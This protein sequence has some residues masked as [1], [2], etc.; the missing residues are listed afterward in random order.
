MR[1]GS[2]ARITNLAVW[3]AA[4]EG[5]GIIDGSYDMLET[6]D[7]L[8]EEKGSDV[9]DDDLS[10][11]EED[12]SVGEEPAKKKKQKI[13]LTSRIS[14]EKSREIEMDAEALEKARSIIKK[15][16]KKQKKAKKK[17]SK[18]ND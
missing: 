2:G 10:V 7:V 16:K 4:S 17:K 6:A 8:D 13:E 9:D 11:Q 1:I 15:A 14:G 3:S 12:E 18:S 5:D